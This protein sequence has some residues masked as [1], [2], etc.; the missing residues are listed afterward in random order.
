MG[1]GISWEIGIDI[2]ILQYIKQITK[3]DLLYM[4]FL[5]GSVVRNPLTDGRD[6]GDLGS[7]PGSGRF[8]AEGN[9]EPL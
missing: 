7:I 4:G 6:A 1:R 5:G 2:Y 9:G 3:K 8:P